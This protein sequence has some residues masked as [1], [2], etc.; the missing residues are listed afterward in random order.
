MVKI[1]KV[2]KGIENEKSL[3]LPCPL[4]AQFLSPE[5]AI[6]IRVSFKG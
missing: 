3:F 1:Q 4:A 6:D 5:A 2:Y